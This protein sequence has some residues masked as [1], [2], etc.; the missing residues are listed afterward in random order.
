MFATLAVS[1]IFAI[2]ELEAKNAVFATNEDC[3][4]PTTVLATLAN[5]ELDTVITLGAQAVPFQINP[6]PEF[7]GNVVVSTSTNA[8]ILASVKLAYALAFV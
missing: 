5:S 2:L 7:G 3:T 6:Y 4:I 1:A 8:L